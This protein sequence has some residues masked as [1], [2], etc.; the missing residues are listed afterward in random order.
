MEIIRVPA[1][2][3]ALLKRIFTPDITLREKSTLFLGGGIRSLSNPG[4]AFELT[5]VLVFYVYFD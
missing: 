2:F 1:M 5:R 3:S 4:I